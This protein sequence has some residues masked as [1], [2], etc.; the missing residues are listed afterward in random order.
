MTFYSGDLTPVLLASGTAVNVGTEVDT[1]F[2]ITTTVLTARLE[3]PMFYVNVVYSGT[4]AVTGS[5]TLVYQEK[6]SDMLI[7]VDK[8]VYVDPL[9]KM[10][11]G[12]YIG[13]V[14]FSNDFSSIN[15]KSVT[16]DL[17]VAISSYKVYLIGKITH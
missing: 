12:V 15:L 3:K 5:M 2:D 17:S 9:V 8:T 7:G 16:N 11:D 14:M 4:A 1:A 10:V 6:I 13:G